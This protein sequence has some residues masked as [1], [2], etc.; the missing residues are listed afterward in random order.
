MINGVGHTEWK[1]ADLIQVPKN[2]G[3]NQW[4][5]EST[6]FTRQTHSEQPAVILSEIMD[7]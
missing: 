6:Q 2:I 4:Q 7:T 1:I 5:W 3:N